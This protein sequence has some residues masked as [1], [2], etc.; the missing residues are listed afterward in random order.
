MSHY[1][2]IYSVL[3]H[4]S[5]ECVD[6]L[7]SNIF[8]FNHKY[9]VLIVLNLNSYLGKMLT[10]HHFPE[11]VLVYPR[12]TEKR[13]FHISILQGH[14]DNYNYIKEMKINC[15]YYCAISSNSLFVRSVQMDKIKEYYDEHMTGTGCYERK[16]ESLTGW[17]WD[18]FN[19]NSLLVDVFRK[20]RIYTY[21]GA[22][23]GRFYI[24]EIWEQV[25]QNIKQHDLISKVTLNTAFEEIIPSSLEMYHYGF[26]VPIICKVYWHVQDYRVDVKHI[27]EFNKEE[28]YMSMVKRV[29]RDIKDPI[30][31]Y[32]RGL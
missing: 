12:Y 26:K 5:L 6:D 15:D 19:K 3:C 9:N 22:M 4:E 28:N 18:A 30:R 7:I 27:E 25:I 16:Y 21:S 31:T 32:I 8:K 10:D 14:I 11:N 20:N 17:H 1:D 29:Y 24:K 13:T 23:E 2:I